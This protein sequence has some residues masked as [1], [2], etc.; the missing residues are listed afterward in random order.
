MAEPWKKTYRVI[1][2]SVVKHAYLPDAIAAHPRFEL[3]AVADDPDRPEWTHARNQAY[4]D[5]KGI[6]YIQDVEQALAEQECDIAVISSE[7]E[8]HCSLAMRAVRRGLHIIVDKPLSTHVQACEDLTQALRS[9]SLQGMVWSRNFLPSLIEARSVVESQ[10]LGELLTIHCDFYFS[11]DAGP[12]KVSEAPSS[13][14]IQWLKRQLDAHADGSDGG[15]GVEPMGELQIEGIYPLAYVH[16]LCGSPLK[17]V[18]ATTATHF[19]QANV[20]NEVDDLAALSFVLENGVTGSLAMGR[21][22]AAS[23]PDIGEI[24]L[25]LIGTAG[26][27]V[28]SEARPEV[29]LYYKDQPQGEFKHLRIANRND[30]LLMD[31]FADALDFGAELPLDVETACHIA[32]VIRAAYQSVDEAQAVTITSEAPS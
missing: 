16:A 30:F 9:R 13:T 24:K 28:I 14:P 2:L 7:A 21:I 29:G 22:G 4:A 15:L 25:H 10:G 20:D 27:L 8:R 31:A 11:K 19:H 12:P 6:P 5:E 17:E 3:M 18:F 32:R 1:V 23:H 26:A